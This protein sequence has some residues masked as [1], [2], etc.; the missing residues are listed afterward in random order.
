M[1]QCVV[2]VA[3][4]AALS[5]GCGPR[6]APAA[7]A[8]T[9][10]KA[11]MARQVANAVEVGEGDYQLRQ[12]RA[13]M[14]ADPGN[15][16]LRL[17][18]A[19]RYESMGFEEVALEHYRL[20]AQSFP[21]HPGLEMKL[22]RSL[23]QH[24]MAKEALQSLEGFLRRHPD[25]RYAGLRSWAG[26]LSDDLGEWKAGEK[27]HRAAIAQSEQPQTA[28]H[29]NLGHNLLQQGNKKEAAQEFRRSLELDSRN[30]VARNNLGIA[31]S[32][33]PKEAVLQWQAQT[34]PATAHSNLAAVL[35]EEGRY[36]QAREELNIALGYKPDHPAALKNLG[37]VAELDG[38]PAV[39]EKRE[40][41]KSFWSRVSSTMGKIFW[42]PGEPA[43][44][45][46]N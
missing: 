12:L 14:A 22:A 24:G 5:S 40:P 36:Q 37:L 23:R 32:A 44:R 27:Y 34:D 25:S 16:D 30:E 8:P 13:R 7:H 17:E 6:K 9:G 4:A 3:L 33:N 29:N 26:I 38:R 10:V 21:D 35:I 1:K 42:T 18:L 11:T 15:L 43:R 31:L 39:I 2:M 28:L 20:A 19:A 45:S 46:G 41:P